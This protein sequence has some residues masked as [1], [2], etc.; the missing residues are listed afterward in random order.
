MSRAIVGKVIVKGKLV[1]DR[2]L[3]VGGAGAAGGVD[4]EIA[5]DGRGRPYV[6]GSS[7]AGP[8]RSWLERA[9]GEELCKALFGFVTRDEGH[10][11]KADRKS[12]RLNSSH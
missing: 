1:A 12:T 2:A 10:A 3:S 11:S 9:A 6:P 4:L 8:M 5:L 7:L